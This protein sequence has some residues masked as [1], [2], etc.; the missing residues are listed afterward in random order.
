MTAIS[1][2]SSQQEPQP[3]PT[4]SAFSSSERIGNC[5]LVATDLKATDK[6]GV[7]ASS[8]LDP[9]RLIQLGD[10]DMDGVAKLEKQTSCE[11]T[12]SIPQSPKPTLGSGGGSGTH[13]VLKSPG[14]SGN[15]AFMSVEDVM[16]R[17]PNP[18]KGT[19]TASYNTKNSDDV[20]SSASTSKPT[21]LTALLKNGITASN[22]AAPQP[23]PVTAQNGAVQQALFSSLLN[24]L[25]N[26]SPIAT[27][28]TI[29]KPSSQGNAPNGSKITPLVDS[30]SSSGVK[31]VSPQVQPVPIPRAVSLANTFNPSMFLANPAHLAQQQLISAAAAVSSGAILSPNALLPNMTFAP[32]IASLPAICGSGLVQGPPQSSATYIEPSAT[33]TSSI[34]LEPQAS[35]TPP[36]QQPPPPPPTSV[37]RDTDASGPSPPKKPRL[38]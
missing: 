15:P 19:Q 32:Y 22:P 20:S 28:A 10:I 6:S 29:S 17:S 36:S 1:A 24:S 16:V 12:S 14:P 3:P 4:T 35:T 33:K 27:P 18:A 9:P 30:A 11:S 13:G 38:E 2:L 8:A 21:A 26:Q 7:L 31:K 23:P 25:V 5:T 37:S 34:V